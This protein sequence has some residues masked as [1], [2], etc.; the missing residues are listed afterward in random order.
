VNAVYGLVRTLLMALRAYPSRYLAIVF[1]AE[2]D[3]VRHEAYVDYKATRKEMPERLVPQ[4]ELAKQV[5]DVLGVPRFELVRYEA[6]DVL[7]TLARMAERE[8]VPVLL[9][10]G[11]K[12][13]AQLVSEHVHLLRPGRRPSDRMEELDPAGVRAR[14]GVPP[15]LMA[16]LLALVGDSSDN[17]PGVKGIGEKGARALLAMYGSLDAALDAAERHPNPRLGKA[18]AEGRQAAALSRSLVRLHEVP[19]ETDLGQLVPRAFEEDALR[20]LL[21][22]LDFRSVLADLELDTPGPQAR[23]TCVTDEAAFAQL[24]GELRAADA[25]AVDLETTSTDPLQAEIVGVAVAWGSG[26]GSYVPVAHTY[27]GAPE[28]LPLERVLEGL[29]PILEGARP[30]IL[31]QNLKY[32]MQVLSRYW[33]RAARDPARHD[34]RPLAPSPGRYVAQPRGGRPR[35]AG[36]AGAEL[37][38][39]RRRG[40]GHHGRGAARPGSPLRGLGRRGRGPVAC[41]A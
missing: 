4:V 40:R 10:T 22:E 21:E 6:D 36:R 1:D 31:G 35:H 14:Y 38:G 7:A 26:E 23:H 32:D 16:D 27:P 29:R 24:L 8:R 13:M 9:L 12:D 3:T 37:P 33:D 20:Q 15:E 17:I 30:Q 11:D 41:A 19:L 39:A 5:A 28:Q 18:L 34:A 25:V 2:G